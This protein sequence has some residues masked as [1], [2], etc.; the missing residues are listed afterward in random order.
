MIR[1]IVIG[2]Y[3]AFGAVPSAIAQVYSFTGNDLLRRCD[4]PYANEAQKLSYS[5]F[6]SGYLQ[7]VQQMH[8]VVIGFHKSTP[9]YCEPTATGNY[10]LL[11]R[12]VVKWLTSNPEQLHRDARVLVTR[13]LME[14]FPCR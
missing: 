3:I 9:F 2:L 6:C 13:A 5:S 1:I 4:G 14:T 12:V 11:E 10:D 7:G 8:H